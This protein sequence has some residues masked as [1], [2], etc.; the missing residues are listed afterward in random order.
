MIQTEEYLQQF[1]QVKS[2]AERQQVAIQYNSFYDQLTVEDQRK[3]DQVMSV[4]WP[5]ISLKIDELDPLMAQAEQFLQGE[6]AYQ[7]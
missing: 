6:S 1:K 5:G 4:L 3:A 7:K 2:L